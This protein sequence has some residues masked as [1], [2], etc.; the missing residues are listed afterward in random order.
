M[1]FTQH[2]KINSTTPKNFQNR[3]QNHMPSYPQQMH[4]FSVQNRQQFQNI[5]HPQPMNQ[6]QFMHHGSQNYFVQPQR[7]GGDMNQSFMQTTM[8][9]DQ[10]A[11]SH[12]SGMKCTK[13][14]YKQPDP[15]DL[16]QE[17]MNSRQNCL[18]SQ[19]QYQ[20][21]QQQEVD[22]SD[23]EPIN[24]EYFQC[25]PSPSTVNKQR[26]PFQ[27]VMNSMRQY[28]MTK[29]V[30]KLHSQTEP[31]HQTFTF[32]HEEEGCEEIADLTQQKLYRSHTRIVSIPNGVKIITEILKDENDAAT[33]SDDNSS[34]PNRNNQNDEKWMNKQ[35]EVSVDGVELG[36]NSEN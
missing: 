8:P 5:N 27:P 32:T 30:E 20:D 23:E 15:Q 17:M 11:F 7:S 33:D 16:T 9:Y 24:I 13:N 22:V 28:S 36:T 35:I 25:S 19:P 6:N 21:E 31:N 14:T 29:P 2:N 18:V 4:A 12:D 26:N 3:L 10:R 34:C 1:D